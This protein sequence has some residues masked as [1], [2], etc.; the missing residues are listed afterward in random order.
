M[1]AT[2]WMGKLPLDT[3]IVELERWWTLASDCVGFDP[4]LRLFSGPFSLHPFST[5]ADVPVHRGPGRTIRQ[6]SGALLLSVMPAMYGGGAK[7]EKR[8]SMQSRLAQI[9]LS[10]GLNLP[11]ANKVTAQLVQHAGQQ[12]LAKALEVDDAVQQWSQI[13]ALM[14]AAGIQGPEAQEVATR[15]AKRVQAHVT[16]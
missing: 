4:N 7:D 14:A 2:I 15:I 16:R 8:Q 12:Q 5:L 1:A 9:C 10:H 6:R 11:E 3:C 13:Q